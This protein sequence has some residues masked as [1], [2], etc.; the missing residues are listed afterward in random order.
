MAFGVWIRLKRVLKAWRSS[1]PEV[2][3]LLEKHNGIL[4]TGWEEN[5]N[6]CKLMEIYPNMKFVE[7]DLSKLINN[8]LN[9]KTIPRPNRMRTPRT[10]RANITSAN[11]TTT[12]TPTKSSFRPTSSESSV[13]ATATPV[14]HLP[15][16]SPLEPFA[17]PVRSVAPAA[18][19]WTVDPGSP[20]QQVVVDGGS[21][22][23]SNSTP[24]KKNNS[25]TLTTDSIDI[26][27]SIEGHK[28]ITTLTNLASEKDAISF[29]QDLKESFG[30]FCEVF[31][32]F[33][34]LKSELKGPAHPKNNYG[35]FNVSVDFEFSPLAW[36]ALSVIKPDPKSRLQ[37][38]EAIHSWSY[39]SQA[40]L[41]HVCPLMAPLVKEKLE[42]LVED[43]KYSDEWPF[44]E[45]VECF[46]SRHCMFKVETSLLNKAGEVLQRIDAGFEE[47]PQKIISVYGSESPFIK[48]CKFVKK[49]DCISSKG[50]PIHLENWNCREGTCS[51]V[52]R[53][54]F[55]L[56]PAWVRLG[57][58]FMQYPQ[59][60]SDPLEWD[61]REMLKIVSSALFPPAARQSARNLQ[62]TGNKL[63]HVN[64][65]VHHA[66]VYDQMAS[67]MKGLGAID[68]KID[69]LRDH[70]RK[71]D[72]FWPARNSFEELLQGEKRADYLTTQQLE[73]IDRLLEDS[74]GDWRVLMAPPG[75]G[76]TFML[77]K[78]AAVE[79]QTFQA[80]ERAPL[81][82]LLLS[83]SP[84][85]QSHT[86]RCCAL[87]IRDVPTIVVTLGVS[88][89]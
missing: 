38:K 4:K 18:D 64:L 36:E 63:A 40:L 37:M 34:S 83:H 87:C 33:C 50:F 12:T 29:V 66:A 80:Q 78:L 26:K 56:Q 6:L 65:R 22:S 46:L 10:E 62:C 25:S 75:C 76:K 72:A 1:V 24:R 8:C 53:C 42:K 21:V 82:L 30:K 5:G 51:D 86:A 49:I 17:S 57:A 16:S 58:L 27:W 39:M 55:H 3:S 7:E 23:S 45:H 32:N 59:L 48:F 85:L 52:G 44:Q 88:S 79:L 20:P 28:Y 69:A 89:I 71:N 61:P 67:L 47:G 41:S 70:E 54:S 11:T 35:G 73:V 77:V 68:C 15:P 43:L 60:K 74:S 31:H 19:G 9:G 84:R 13:S 81:R 2:K 14:V